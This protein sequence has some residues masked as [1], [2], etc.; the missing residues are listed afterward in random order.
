M[1]PFKKWETERE[2]VTWGVSDEPPSHLVAALESWWNL[3]GLKP[4]R[5]FSDPSSHARHASP[6]QS[7]QRNHHSSAD[8]TPARSSLRWTWGGL[9]ADSVTELFDII[10]LHPVVLNW[11]YIHFWNVLFF[12]YKKLGL[13]TNW[14]S[15]PIHFWNIVPYNH[16]WPDLSMV[17]N[18]FKN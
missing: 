12:I 2:R 10:E 4:A 7:H 9:G 5:F 18:H 3:H 14:E 11:D 6:N 17:K 13:Y 15:R 1:H 8:A 16:F